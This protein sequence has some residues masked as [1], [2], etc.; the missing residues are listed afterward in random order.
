MDNI[1]N[2][3]RKATF[4]GFNREDVI[5]YIE[6][7]KNEH[8]DYKNKAERNIEELKEKIAELEAALSVALNAAQKEEK[9]V[10]IDISSSVDEINKATD[11]LKETA[12]KVCDDIGEFLDKVLTS[13]A[14]KDDGC[15]VEIVISGD[16]DEK[17]QEN[18]EE[19][20]P[21]DNEF[22]SILSQIADDACKI[23]HQANENPTEFKTEKTQENKNIL[24]DLFGNSAFCV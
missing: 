23:K 18:E 24:D 11:R 14:H 4:G 3:F 17:A 5:N 15:T 8:F 12:D 20:E 7:I 13:S 10:E 1:N 9:T 22:T 6:R 21:G 19:Q 2:L 16:A